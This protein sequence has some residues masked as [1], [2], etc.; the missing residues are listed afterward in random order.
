MPDR[1]RLLTFRGLIITAAAL[2]ALAVLA[3]VLTII[4]LR[5]D[6]IQ[7]AERDAGNIATVL[8]EQ[9]ANSV[10]AIDLTLAQLQN[11]I[12]ATGAATPEQLRAVAAGADMF[13]ILRSHLTR[14]SEAD[15]ITLVGA[16][17]RILNNSRVFPS[18]K[19]DLSDREYFQ[20]ARAGGSAE[21][22][23]TTIVNRVTGRPPSSLP[24]ASRAPI[25]PFWA[26]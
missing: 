16:D 3:T 23:V 9:T 20:L 1:K 17:G 13:H 11:Q 8:A 2:I 15:V 14:L 19:L 25:T 21:L 6:A 10:Q 18:H 22:F 4:G 26:S 24:A 7:D 5:G 12:S